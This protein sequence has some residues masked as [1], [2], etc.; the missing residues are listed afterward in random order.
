[1][2]FHA[3]YTVPMTA[4]TDATIHLTDVNAG[5]W[6]RFRGCDER[7]LAF[8]CSVCRLRRYAVLKVYGN[9][10]GDSLVTVKIDGRVRELWVGEYADP[11]SVAVE[12]LIACETDCCSDT[13]GGHHA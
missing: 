7:R 1:M 13:N 9:G 8:T 12:T 5:P 10:E 11:L 2:L 6:K 4:M 3:C